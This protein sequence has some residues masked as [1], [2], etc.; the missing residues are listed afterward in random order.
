MRRDRGDEVRLLAD[1]RNLLLDGLRVVGPDLR[2]ETVL[3]R[4]DDATAVGVVLRVGGGDDEHIQVEAQQVPADLDVALLHDVQ[5]RHLDAF[6]EIG[7]LVDR[8]DSAVTA[9]DE[10]V[11]DRL[12]V[13]ERTALGDLDRVDVA[14]QVGHRCVGSGQLLDVSHGAMTPR[15]RELVT[16]IGCPSKGSGRDRMERMLAQLGTGDDRRPLVEQAGKAAQQPRL[17]L[18]ALAEQHDV[19]S[20]EE[21]ALQLGDH[22]G[23]EAVDAGPRVAPVGER[24]QEVLP[25]FDTERPVGVSRRAQL[26]GRGDRGR[27]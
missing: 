3:Q 21:C 6:R 26:A 10:S 15:D 17:A 14:D 24:R 23:V 25:Q 27:R 9:G 20:G 2:A 16:Q 11:V 19:V 12:G 22:R 18:T 13:A 5:Q 1:D 4:S 8:Y 7:Q